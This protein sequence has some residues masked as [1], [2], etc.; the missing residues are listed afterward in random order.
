MQKNF[1]KKK[2]TMGLLS[3]DSATG[4]IILMRDLGAV[5]D[6]EYVQYTLLKQ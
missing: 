3:L 6:I 4:S 1:D 2:Y 5:A